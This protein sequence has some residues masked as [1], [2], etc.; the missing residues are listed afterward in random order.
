MVEKA[1]LTLLFNGIDENRKRL[2]PKEN[3]CANVFF[4][5]SLGVELNNNGG[6]TVKKG[7]LLNGPI[8]RVISLLGH[9]DSI[10]IADAGLPIPEDVERI[11]LAVTHGMPPFLATVEAVIAELCVERMVLATEFALTKS[12]VHTALL[13]MFSSLESTQGNIITKAECS[14]EEFKERTRNCRAVIRTGECTPYANVILH[15]GVTF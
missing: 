6:K 11:D 2:E 9:G 12:E 1:F 3:V 14:H 13:K 10:C 5:V 7:T 15:A 4:W 8:S